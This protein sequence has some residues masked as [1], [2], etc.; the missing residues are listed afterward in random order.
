MFAVGEYRPDAHQ[1][2]WFS[3]PRLI[4][5]TDRV[6]GGI[7]N[8][9]EYGAYSSLTEHRSR[10]IL[11]YPDRKHFLLGRLVPDELLGDMNVPAQ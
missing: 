6:P 5:D 3:Q 10:R 7:Q 9:I 8:R 11:W 2:I 1:P 4:A